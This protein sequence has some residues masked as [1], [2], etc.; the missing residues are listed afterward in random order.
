M[1][2]VFISY[3]S[4]D[5][6]KVE[7]LVRLLEERGW[8]VWWDRRIAVGKTY[9]DVISDALDTSK[10]V[11]VVW[12]KNSV[13]SKWVRA[14]ASEG[15]RRDVLAPVL[16][17]D[18]R[19]PLEFRLIQ[20]S[21]L[22]DWGGE[23]TNPEVTKFLDSVSAILESPQGQPKSEV[24]SIE[25]SRPQDSN[26]QK[27]AVSARFVLKTGAV[28][29]SAVVLALL[30][31]KFL[32]VQNPRVT[33]NASAIDTKSGTVTVI[34]ITRSNADVQTVVNALNQQGYKA[35][36]AQRVDKAHAP[37]GPEVRWYYSEDE[38]EAKEILGIVTR[39]LNI[40]PKPN[41]RVNDPQVEKGHS[42]GEIRVYL[43]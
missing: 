27:R 13:T 37:D 25:N 11:V 39:T 31:W 30:V 14:E 2:D 7:P 20:A 10:C 15:A 34:P 24:E 12:T 43:D 41:S 42:K 26:G 3:S 33:N 4:S 36:T 38:T 16:L 35:S 9:D 32:P 19:V 29:I 40:A 1:A 18:V 8:S 28:I 5:R 22:F 17:E 21:R 23:R 6:P